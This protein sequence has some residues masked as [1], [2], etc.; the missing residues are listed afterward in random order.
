MIEELAPYIE[1]TMSAN[2][3]DGQLP[4]CQSSAPFGDTGAPILLSVV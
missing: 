2:S 3:V 1:K 4:D